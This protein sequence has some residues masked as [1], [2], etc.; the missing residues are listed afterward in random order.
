MT[1][2][3]QE[4]LFNSTSADKF[5]KPLLPIAPLPDPI[6]QSIDA[7]IALHTQ[8]EKNLSSHQRILEAITAFFSRP[9]FLYCTLFIVAAWVI[10]NFLSPQ[11]GLPQLDPPPFEELDVLLGVGSF[12]MTIGVLIAQRRQEKLAE[13]RAQLSLQLNL[14]SEQKI[15]KI[16]DLLE[17][18]RRDLP[19]VHDRLDY[20]AEVMK[21]AAN[22]QA[23]IT[24]LEETLA[25]ELAELQNQE[26]V[27]KEP[28]S[29]KDE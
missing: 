18:L 25:A 2:K 24:A 4:Q 27:A 22:P 12:L 15:A 8:S 26:S 7:V 21:Q 13:Q 17:E 1:A 10:F 29:K 23:V 14:L 28:F 16:I 11:L 5:N 9:T 3:R 20:E 6:G 19:N